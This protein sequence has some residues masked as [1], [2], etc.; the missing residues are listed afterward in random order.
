MKTF[1]EHLNQGRLHQI[2]RKAL[3]LSP[4]G[5]VRNDVLVLSKLSKVS[6]QELQLEWLARDIHPWDRD[7]PAPDQAELFC[8]QALQD[9]E[10]AILRLFRMLPDIAQINFRVLDPH[11]SNRVILAGNV[12]RGEISWACRL[13]SIKMRLLMMGV[14]FLMASGHLEPLAA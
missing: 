10:S 12:E 13:G 2:A 3:K 4:R 5:C 7:L 8:Q 11:A 9:T 14:R 6:D 1:L